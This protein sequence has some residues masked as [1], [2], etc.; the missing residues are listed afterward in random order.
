MGAGYDTTQRLAP[1]PA[2]HSS[3]VQSPAP[4][5]QPQQPQLGYNAPRSI[6]V[7]HL[8]DA[9]DAQIPEETR[10]Q[11][12]RDEAGRVLFFTQPPLKRAH[13]GL[14]AESAALGHSAR[15]LADRARETEDRRAKRRARDELRRDEDARRAEAEGR[16]AQRQK[17]E[18]AELAEDMYKGWVATMDCESEV[19]RQA[20]G[21]WSVRD[22]V[23]N[24]VVRP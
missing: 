16:E 23:I 19:L 5:M 7:Y 14:S 21:G 13:T 24:D 15:Y 11:L 20:Y 6:E 2:R 18:L 8:A 4:G 22:E 9:V 12:Q 17:Q 3:M 1:S 10:S